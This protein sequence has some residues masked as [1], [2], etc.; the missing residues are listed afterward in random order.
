MSF[1][2]THALLLVTCFALLLV[3]LQAALAANNLPKLLLTEIIPNG[4]NVPHPVTGA[5][6]TEAFEMMEI[7]N[8][9]NQSIA[10][11][12]FKI[13]FGPAGAETELAWLDGSDAKS[14][15]AGGVLVVWAKQATNPFTV[16]DFYQHNVNKNP[17]LK[18]DQIAIVLGPQMHNTQ[19]RSGFLVAADGSV[20]CKFAY[21]GVSSETVDDMAIRY[22]YPIDGSNQLR[23]ISAGTPSTPGI[24][25]A[26]QIPAL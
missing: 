3:P 14:I 10:L 8:N 23:K 15:P 12:D 17:D 13:M 22:A 25:D 19:P 26:D 21:D 4:K 7:Y 1:R 24:I 20:I 9:S 18:M 6:Y 5:N 16:Q 11:K 2:K